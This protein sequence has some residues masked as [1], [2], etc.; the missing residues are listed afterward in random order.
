M[1]ALRWIITLIVYQSCEFLIIYLE[2]TTL[3]IEAHS[4]KNEKD[5]FLSN[6]V[7]EK[8]IVLALE[9]NR[10]FLCY[11]SASELANEVLL[12]FNPPPPPL[13]PPFRRR[14]FQKHFCEWKVFFSLIQFSLKIVPKGPIDNNPAMV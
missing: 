6:R 11:L 10:K 2:A 13:F 9:L 3:C 12:V 5:R 14:Y 4:Y 1:G 7:G 8:N